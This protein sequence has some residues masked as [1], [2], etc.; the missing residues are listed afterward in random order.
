MVKNYFHLMICIYDITL[1]EAGAVTKYNGTY[2][3]N[4]RASTFT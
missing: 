1:R 2:A 3:R 4:E